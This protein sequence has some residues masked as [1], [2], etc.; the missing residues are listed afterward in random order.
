MPSFLPLLLPLLLLLLLPQFSHSLP[1]QAY[2]T[3]LYGDDWVLPIRVMMHSLYLNSPDVR[4]GIRDRVVIVTA[5]SEKTKQQLID[6]NITIIDVPP[7]RSPYANDP[8]F[9]SRF[10]H[11]M[12]KLYIFNLTQYSRLL[13]IDADGLVL[14]DLSPAFSCGD[15]CATF[16]NPCHFNVGLMQITPNTTLFNNMIRQLPQLPSYD[17]TDQGFLNSY[18]PDLLDAPMYYPP[19]ENTTQPPLTGFF[20]FPFSWHVDHSSFFPTLN[21]EF[22]KGNRCGQKRLLEW[23]GPPFAKPWIWWNYVLLD[24]SWTWYHYR[25][26]LPN[27]YPPPSWARENG[28]ALVLLTYA[29]LISL[30]TTFESQRPNLLY[31]IITILFP[32]LSPFPT[33]SRRMSCLFPI[34]S[35]W[36]IWPLGFI[37]A[38]KSVPDILPPLPATIVFLHVRT[39]ITTIALLLVASVFCLGQRGPKGKPLAV[40]QSGARTAF[41]KIFIWAVLDAAY[42]VIWSGVLWKIHFAGMAKK[43]YA[44]AAI[45]AS[46]LFLVG[47]MLAHTTVSWLS[48]RDGGISGL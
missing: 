37:I 42:M 22:E 25:K 14:N 4:A 1:K 27:P 12:T 5:T 7:V 3:L 40:S 9:D 15:F 23:L 36:I 29:I 21:F 28:L 39:L 43:V 8:K 33:P 46:Q 20:R 16:I 17:G 30:I 44:M 32:R 2:V 18:F 6:D 45:V 35:G 31:R 10:M 24:L 19:P 26:M 41:R 34:I 38:W 48:V 47:A 13:F 11:V